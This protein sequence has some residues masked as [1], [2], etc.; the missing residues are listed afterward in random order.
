MRNDKCP[1]RGSKTNEVP[2]NC[3]DRYTEQ[4]NSPGMR[5]ALFVQQ[6]LL[7][8]TPRIPRFP[9]PFFRF[10]AVSAPVDRTN[11][12]N[13]TNCWRASPLDRSSG[14]R[15]LRRENSSRSCRYQVRRLVAANLRW[16]AVA[17]RTPV[18]AAKSTTG[19][20]GIGR[21]KAEPLK[22]HFPKRPKRIQ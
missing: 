9:P 19:I 8:R 14:L 1:M 18:M 3:N 17:T 21:R 20:S 4:V 22:C 13:A 5:K 16:R 15:K 10:S 11:R 7:P 12:V 2:P 6:S